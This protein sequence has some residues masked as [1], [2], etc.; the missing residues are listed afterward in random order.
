MRSQKGPTVDEQGR[1]DSRAHTDIQESGITARS[2]EA[3]FSQGCSAHIGGNGHIAVSSEG[4]TDWIRSPW[5]NRAALD[6][7]RGADELGQPDPHLLD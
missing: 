6:L 2:T 4:F 3:R 5:Q 7:A 1:A